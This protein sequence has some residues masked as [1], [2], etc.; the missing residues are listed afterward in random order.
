MYL[1]LL[2]L[3]HFNPLS[4]DVTQK[5]NI[6]FRFWIILERLGEKKGQINPCFFDGFKDI[7]IYFYIYTRSF[8]N[9]CNNIIIKMLK[10]CLETDFEIIN[11]ELI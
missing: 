2:F 11:H 1:S 5:K 6:C 8:K 9:F 7:Y 3:K 4:N 10:Y